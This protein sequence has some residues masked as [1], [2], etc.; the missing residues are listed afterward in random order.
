MKD[1]VLS[2]IIDYY[3]KTNFM[4]S[5]REVQNIMNYKNHNTIYK[6]FLQLEKD[7]ILIHNKEKRKWCLTNIENDYL[8]LKV[9]N[10]DSYISVDNNKDNVVIY[11]MNNNNFK[12]SNILKNDYLIIKKTKNLNNY[13]LGLFIFNNDY[14]V[15]N[16]VFLD[17]FYMLSDSKTKEVLSK[18]KIIGKV[19]GL[20]RKQL[21]K[22]RCI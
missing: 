19:I 11:K 21:I 16:Y 15:M 14:H 1:K 5:V 13:D 22:K 7:G 17:G 18:V 12:D 8:R 10:E 6:A 4:P 2:V 20:Q 3:K 9:L